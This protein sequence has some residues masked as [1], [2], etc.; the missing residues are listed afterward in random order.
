MTQRRRGFL[1]RTTGDRPDPPAEAAQRL[2]EHARD[3]QREARKQLDETREERFELEGRLIK[4]DHEIRTPLSHVI[5]YLE[6]LLDGEAGPLSPEQTAMMLRIDAGARH[7][8]S[9]VESLVVTTERSTR[10]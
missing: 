9:V 1:G 8:K 7:L 4:L 3:L 5:G 6:L 2:L 10:P